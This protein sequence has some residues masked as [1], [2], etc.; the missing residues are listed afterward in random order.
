MSNRIC[1]H[2]LNREKITHVLARRSRLYFSHP[3][4]LEV[5]YSKINKTT[6]YINVGAMLGISF[7]SEVVNG[8]YDF[9]FKYLDKTSIQNAL[10]VFKSCPNADIVN[11]LDE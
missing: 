7:P 3:Y 2:L 6:T 4:V 10:E 9:S 5:K 11:K 8:S 1:D